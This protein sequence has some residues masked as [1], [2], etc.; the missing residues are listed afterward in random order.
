MY[1]KPFKFDVTVRYNKYNMLLL[2]SVRQPDPAS[3]GRRVASHYVSCCSIMP[4]IPSQVSKHPQTRSIGVASPASAIHTHSS[5]ATYNNR[6]KTNYYCRAKRVLR[7]GGCSC[8][9]CSSYRRPRT[10][11]ITAFRQRGLLHA[12]DKSYTIDGSRSLEIHASL[13]HLG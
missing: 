2:L 10:R 11:V 9:T 4:N 12:I 1:C 3:G 13:C 5:C 6:W 7:G 8:A